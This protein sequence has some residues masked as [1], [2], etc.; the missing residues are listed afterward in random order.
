[1][2]MG[3]G[4]AKRHMRTLKKVEN[5]CSRRTGQTTR[6]VLTLIGGLLALWIAVG[7]TLCFTMGDR[8]PKVAL[9]WWPAGNLP[10]IALGAEF[11]VSNAPA[12]SGVGHLRQMAK[13]ATI[14][15]PVDSHAL[16][17]LA[18]IVDYAGDRNNA[19]KLFSLSEAISR[20]NSVTQLWLISDAVDRGDVAGAIEHYDRALRASLELREV[21]LPILVDAAGETQVRDELLPVIAKRPRWWQS[22]VTTL[23]GQSDSPELIGGTLRALNLDIRDSQ[24]RALAEQLLLRLVAIKAYGE[25]ARFANA[26]EGMPPGERTLRGGAFETEEG[27]LPFAW[28]MRDEG[29]VRAYLERVATDSVGLRLTASAGSSGRVAWQMISLGAGVHFLSGVAGGVSKE[30]LSQPWIEIV[31]V[32]GESLGRF[33]LPPGPDTEGVSFRFP[34]EVRKGDCDV[35]WLNIMTAPAVNTEAWVD[36][37]TISSGPT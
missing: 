30:R 34:I 16:S 33:S 15:E 14:R 7:I 3:T 5:F 28:Q 26:L 23:S 20:R 6:M 9:A 32:D 19:R 21:L 12:T 24:E 2:A 10:K 31:C 18:T 25:A 27:V 13:D 22:F 8:I 4:M 35:Q 29:A 36:N 1:M 37:L 17:L 11:M